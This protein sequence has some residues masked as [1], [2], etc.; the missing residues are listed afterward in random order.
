MGSAGSWR[1]LLGCIKNTFL[2]QLQKL[3][4]ESSLTV[5]NIHKT[6]VAILWQFTTTVSAYLNRGSAHISF[7]AGVH[8]RGLLVQSFIVSL[9]SWHLEV[10]IWRLATALAKRVSPSS[11][12][13]Q[14]KFC[15]TKKSP[16][17]GPL[18]TKISMSLVSSGRGFPFG[19]IR[20][21]LKIAHVV[22]MVGDRRKF[23]KFRVQL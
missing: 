13:E 4:C 14:L 18:N 22:W 11:W 10:C 8:L 17:S 23:S 5:S 6:S 2:S 21:Q 16:F 19:K 15:M 12:H 7:A 9:L 20:T 3:E 1:C